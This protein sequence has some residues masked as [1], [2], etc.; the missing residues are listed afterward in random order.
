[1]QK[2]AAAVICLALFMLQ[3]PRRGS[4]IL[5]LIGVE[6]IEREEKAGPD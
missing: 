3:Y 6:R 2:T 1:M 4:R 5:P